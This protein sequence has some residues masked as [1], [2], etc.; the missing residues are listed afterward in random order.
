MYLIVQIIFRT[1]QKIITVLYLDKQFPILTEKKSRKLDL[2]TQDTIKKDIKALIIHKI[3]DASVHQTDNIIISI[4]INT[5]T[6]GLMSN[7]IMIQNTVARFTNTFFN[8]FT[9]SLGNLITSESKHRQEE[10]LDQY[11]FLG[12]WIFGFTTTAFISL[13][14]PLFTLW[15]RMTNTDMLVDNLTMVLY[16]ITVYLGGQS[17]TFY[18]FKV[19]AGI[20]DDDKY[21]ALIQAIVNLIVSIMAVFIIGLPGVY[22]GTIVQRLVALIWKPII[23]YKKQFDKSPKHYFTKTIK[24]GITTTIACVLNIALLKLFFKE[25]TM[26]SFLGMTITTAFVPN[27]FFVLVRG[28]DVEFKALLRRVIYS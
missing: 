11:T 25:I 2:K 15:G 14:Q 9:A 5:I 22:I 16:F 17:L 24:Y 1:V 7:Y 6:V 19:A 26:M 23:V 21:V 8:S 10:V 27:L 18:N 4:F 12:F 28:K 3:G 20:F 13:S